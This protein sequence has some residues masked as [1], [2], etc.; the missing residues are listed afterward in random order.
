MGQWTD[1]LI[2]AAQQ[3][4]HATGTLCEAAN[5]TVQG[6]AAEERLIVS[7]KQVSSSTT[8]LVMAC[9]VKADMD[10]KAF[11]GLKSAS[12][13]VKKATQNLVTSAQRALDIEKQNQEADAQ[14]V[15]SSSRMNNDWL[16]ELKL[17]EEIERSMREQE[18]RYKQL[19]KIRENRY[20][21]R[22]T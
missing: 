16:E 10:S 20:K 22:E 14:N 9:Q 13:D 6:N 2:S 5:D 15:V 21:K 17:K 18:E 7:A 8:Q 1:G 19:K 11:L 3:V 4:A 12:S